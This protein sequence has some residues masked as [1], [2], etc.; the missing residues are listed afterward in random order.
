MKKLTIMAMLISAQL[1]SAPSDYWEQVLNT[2]LDRQ[3]QAH[4]AN[5]QSFPVDDVEPS[6]LFGM[7]IHPLTQQNKL[8]NGIDLPGEEGQPFKAVAHGTVVFA[9]EL[10]S[11]GQ[12]IAIDHGDGIITRYGHA[13]SLK[14]AAGD[15]VRRGDIIGLIGATG[16]VTGPHVH[17]EIVQDGQNVDPATFVAQKRGI[18]VEE[19]RAQ[20][21]ASAVDIDS[22]VD[23]LIT[24]KIGSSNENLELIQKQAKSEDLSLFATELATDV[25][26]K[27]MATIS[28]PD[29]NETLILSQASLNERSL[30]EH[31]DQQTEEI[32][33]NQM[34]K[35][36]ELISAGHHVN[37]ISTDSS[38]QEETSQET[39]LT[40]I[41]E[42]S[43]VFAINDKPL[44]VGKPFLTK[45]TLWAV[46]D[47]TKPEGASVFQSM[48]AIFNSN[49]AAFPD[50]NMNHRYLDVALTIPEKDVVFSI[51]H[52][53]AREK[54]YDDLSQSDALFDRQTLSSTSPKNPSASL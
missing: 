39:N 7:R 47:E 37:V 29:I 3:A 53:Q 51:S 19:F 32:F 48:L 1:H 46:A 12:L 30:T 45:R 11:L 4:L 52:E 15:K 23:S 50:G 26:S 13:H 6:S 9:G 17:F 33:H 21:F 54:Y 43:Q 41:A 44:E 25:E 8:H 27:T 49:P 2:S 10:G 24:Q 36:E 20:L 31:N 34:L 40:P 28:I 22:Y 14:F 5:F 18:S 35:S 38:P 16:T 42:P